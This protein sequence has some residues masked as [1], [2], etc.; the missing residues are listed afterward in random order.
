[1][2]EVDTARIKWFETRGDLNAISFLLYGNDRITILI[3][4]FIDDLDMEIINVRRCK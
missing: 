1:M 3:N 2:N 4:K